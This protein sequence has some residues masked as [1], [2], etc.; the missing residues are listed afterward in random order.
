MNLGEK[1]NRK[2]TTQEIRNS[3]WFLARASMGHD[4]THP[5]SWVPTA[6]Q[7]VEEAGR[8]DSSQT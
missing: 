6:L 1:R 5:A 3:V 8:A 7:E 2:G 4:G